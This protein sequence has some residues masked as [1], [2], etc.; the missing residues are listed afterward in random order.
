MYIF[1]F[2]YYIMH[3]NLEMHGVRAG[4]QG[5]PKNATAT[6]QCITFF[7]NTDIYSTQ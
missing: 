5:V 2:Q 6:K 1:L 3:T 7:N 4:V